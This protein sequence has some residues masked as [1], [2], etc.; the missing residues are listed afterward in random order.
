MKLTIKK[1]S[2]FGLA[3]IFLLSAMLC[4]CFT[5]TVQAKE[6]APSCHS[7]ENSSQDDRASQS[8]DCDCKYKDSFLTQQN[9]PTAKYIAGAP[10]SLKNISMLNG[11]IGEIFQNPILTLAIQGPP[12]ASAYSIPIYLQNSNLRL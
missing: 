9:A 4:C 6:S 8:D 12:K 7:T 3:G 10:L 2:I 1:L 5:D 11:A